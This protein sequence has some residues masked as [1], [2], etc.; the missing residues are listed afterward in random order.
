M[1]KDEAFAELEKH[2]IT[3][4]SSAERKHININVAKRVINQACEEMQMIIDAKD[5]EI[6]K[7]K[8]TE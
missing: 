2:I 5:E 4:I 1:S 3:S 8:E 6:E 7:L